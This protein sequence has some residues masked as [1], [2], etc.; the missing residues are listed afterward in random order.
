MKRRLIAANKVT[1]ERHHWKMYWLWLA[2]AALALGVGLY[3]LNYLDQSYVSSA[4]IPLGLSALCWLYAWIHSQLAI[5]CDVD[6][7]C[8]DDHFKFEKTKE[9]DGNS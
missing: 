7:D 6:S 9:G 4:P 1:R 3:M 2:R 8:A 5:T